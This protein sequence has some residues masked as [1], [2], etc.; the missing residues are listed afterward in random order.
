MRGMNL[1]EHGT[2]EILEMPEQITLKNI[3]ARLDAREP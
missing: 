2:I 1:R 3:I